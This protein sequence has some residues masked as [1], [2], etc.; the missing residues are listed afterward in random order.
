MARDPSAQVAGSSTAAEP[1]CTL[2]AAHA[3][4]LQKTHGPH[5]RSRRRPG[6]LPSLY[7]LWLGARHDITVMNVA[8]DALARIQAGE[9]FDAIVC[10]VHMPNMN[11]F[12]LHVAIQRIEPEQARRFV[13]VTAG[14]LP[15]ERATLSTM[16]NRVLIKP[17]RIDDLRELVRRGSCPSAF[18]ASAAPTLSRRSARARACRTRSN[19]S[20]RYRA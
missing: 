9:R 2:Y 16:P 8:L 13:F 15:E 14:L 12:E 7:A 4:R 5:P 10:D 11:G 19:R 17:F 3:R 18:C 20:V 6:D 1:G